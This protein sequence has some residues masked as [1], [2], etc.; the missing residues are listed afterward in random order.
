LSSSFLVLCS[1]VGLIQNR[2]PQ[3]DLALRQR[4]HHRTPSRTT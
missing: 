4:G 1:G 2:V 3:L